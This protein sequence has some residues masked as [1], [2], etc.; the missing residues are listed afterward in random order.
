MPISPLF[1]VIV[2]CREHLSRSPWNHAQG[3]S[4]PFTEHQGSI[5][6]ASR[7]HRSITRASQKHPRSIAEASQKHREQRFRMGMK[8]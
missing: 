6:E 2:D 1:C 7:K 8:D 5:T 4:R 3:V